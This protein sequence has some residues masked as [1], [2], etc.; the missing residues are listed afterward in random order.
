MESERKNRL[1]KET[2]WGWY[3]PWGTLS[4]GS[5][6][7]PDEVEKIEMIK[8]PVIAQPAPWSAWRVRDD[9]ME[10]V[11]AVALSSFLRSKI[12]THRANKRLLRVLSVYDVANVQFLARRLLLETLG[13]WKYGKSRP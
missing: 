5:Q 6:G 7:R 2:A 8:P 3:L 9:E 13:F 1:G 10:L 4:L 11:D 12:S